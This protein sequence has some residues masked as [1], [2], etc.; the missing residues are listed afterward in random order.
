M[1]KGGARHR[2]GQAPGLLPLLVAWCKMAVCGTKKP[3]H[4]AGGRAHYCIVTLSLLQQ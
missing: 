3:G 1:T 2:C 4:N